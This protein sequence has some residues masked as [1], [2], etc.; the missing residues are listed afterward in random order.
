MPV[1][2]GDEIAVAGPN[3]G[4]VG[5]VNPDAAEILLDHPAHVPG[6][7]QQQGQAVLPQIPPAPAAPAVVMVGEEGAA[8]EPPQEGL[9]TNPF[10]Q[11]V[12]V[13]VSGAGK[14]H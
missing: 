5:A 13:R 9:E 6:F 11:V 12:K 4:G 3:D 8:E 2:V 14:R 10:H 1:A 7:H